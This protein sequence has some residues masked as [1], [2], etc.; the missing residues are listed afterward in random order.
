M[1]VCSVVPL[2]TESLTGVSTAPVIAGSGFDSRSSLNFFFQ[3]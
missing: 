2:T 3:A 1:K